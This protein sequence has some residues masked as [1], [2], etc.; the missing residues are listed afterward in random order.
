MAK[1]LKGT[2]QAGKLISGI[3]ELAIVFAGRDPF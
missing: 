1:N 3:Q 2:K